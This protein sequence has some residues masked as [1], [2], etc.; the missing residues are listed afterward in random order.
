MQAVLSKEVTFEGH[1]DPFTLYRALRLINPSPYMYFMNLGDFNIIGASPEILVQSKQG[2]VTIRPIAGTRKRGINSSED[3]L[4]KIDLI[5]DDKEKA[6]HMML[7]DLARNDLSKVSTVG[8]VNVDEMMIVEKYSHVMH[9]TS[10]VIGQKKDESTAIDCM[11]AALP[12][13]TL[14]GAPKIRAME[15]LAEQENRARGVY[16]GAVGYIGYN[17]TMDTAIVIRTALHNDTSVKVGVGAGIV[18][19]SVG[20]SEWLETEAK[21]AVF[22]EALKYE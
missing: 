7:V 22:K 8:S 19:D 13:G 16:G 20:S 5:E 17:Q 1:Y 15:I 21:L 10:N 11:K 4:N 14:S 2:K 12:A 6:E 3:L 9:M 18:Y